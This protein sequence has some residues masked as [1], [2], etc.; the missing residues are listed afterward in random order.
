MDWRA[1]VKL[2]EPMR[3]D[4]NHGEG[5]IRRVARKFSVHRRMVRAALESALPAEPKRPDRTWP[6]LGEF[7]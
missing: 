2:F 6:K 4:Y 3:R 1:E 5:T 7:R